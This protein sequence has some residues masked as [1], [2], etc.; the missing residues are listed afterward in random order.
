M[1]GAGPWGWPCL[2]LLL[3]VSGF[4]AVDEEEKQIYLQE[5][6]NLT[7]SCV[8]NIMLFSSSLK[9][10]QR[11]ESQG[12]PETLVH[13]STR[14]LSLNQAWA[15]RYLLEDRPSDAIMMVT[16]TELQPQDL[17]LYQCVIYLLPQNF[18]LLL[19]R[20]R[21]TQYKENGTSSRNPTPKGNP[22][23]GL[24]APDT[25]LQVLI[26][27]LTCGFILNKGLVFSVLFV[28][29]QKGLW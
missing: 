6:R 11:V 1:E 3:R 10:W 12:P 29:L 22:D 13:T 18:H 28:L 23:S 2:L 7:V 17:G 25:G 27:V 8:Y 14:N 9:A 16:I 24:L 21:L 4:Q 15:G 5:G 20:I 26:I 19:P